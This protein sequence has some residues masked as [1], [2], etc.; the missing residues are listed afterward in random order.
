MQENPID[1]LAKLA[2]ATSDFAQTQHRDIVAFADVADA[3]ARACAS[4][5]DTIRKA[6]ESTPNAPDIEAH[7]IVIEEAAAALLGSAWFAAKSDIGHNG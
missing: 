3:A 2:K 1:Q 5:A 6:L 4:A 7:I